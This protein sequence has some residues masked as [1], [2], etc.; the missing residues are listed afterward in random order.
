MGT[1]IVIEDSIMT[2]AL[3]VSGFK[4]KKQTVEEALKLLI[5]MKKQSQIRDYRGKL[6]WEG[7]LDKKGTDK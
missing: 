6:Q 3:T 4:T 5:K 1:R 2:E 7:D